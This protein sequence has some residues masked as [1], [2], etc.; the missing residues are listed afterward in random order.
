MRA[1]TAACPCSDTAPFQ[2]SAWAEKRVGSA[3][4]DRLWTRDEMWTDCEAPALKSSATREAS[5]VFSPARS[6]RRAYWPEASHRTLPPSAPETSREVRESEEAP[7]APKPA[8]VVTAA[9]RGSATR[10]SRDDARR[11]TA[12]AGTGVASRAA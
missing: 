6:A 3:S 2:S 11:E 9:W 1:E 7:A 10:V 12:A 8:V 5:P 4:A